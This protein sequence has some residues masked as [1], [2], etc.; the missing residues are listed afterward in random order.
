MNQSNGYSAQVAAKTMLAL[1]DS[2][3]IEITNLK[4]QKLL[5]FAHGMMLSIYERPL[6]NEKFQAWKYGPVVVSLYHALKLFGSSPIPLSSVFVEYWEEI[7]ASDS[8]ALGVMD[9][10]LDQLGGSTGGSLIDFSHD[11]NGPWN[12]VYYDQSKNIE[13]EDMAIKDY[14][15]TIVVEKS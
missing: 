2:K 4:I 6:V 9:S 15:N 3:G 10:V 1:A 8:D 7:P 12:A 11:E 13:I 5:Y 14:F